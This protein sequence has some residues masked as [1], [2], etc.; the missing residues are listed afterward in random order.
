MNRIDETHPKWELL[1]THAARRTFVCNAIMLGIPPSIVMKWTGHSDYRA[2][3]P[4]LEIVDD[5]AKRA[6]SAFDNAGADVGQNVGQENE[7]E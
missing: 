7:D 6:M 4:Y 2:M 5:T 3:K 1:S